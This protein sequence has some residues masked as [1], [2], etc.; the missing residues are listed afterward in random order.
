M[1]VESL[2]SRSLC[3]ALCLHMILRKRHLSLQ[4]AVRPAA[5]HALSP[6]WPACSLR[7]DANALKQKGAYPLHP[8]PKPFVRWHVYALY[9]GACDAHNFPGGPQPANPIVVVVKGAVSPLSQHEEQALVC[10]R[11]E[12]RRKLSGVEYRT[13]PPRTATSAPRPESCGVTSPNGSERC[14][15]SDCTSSQFASSLIPVHT[16]ISGSKAD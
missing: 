1:R 6:D 4:C 13:V 5:E 3:Q 15:S 2:L 7:C 9:F 16:T 14:H 11:V 8:G 10:T 12:P